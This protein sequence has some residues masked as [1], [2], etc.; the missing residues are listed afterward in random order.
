LITLEAYRK[1][2][3]TKIYPKNYIGA[4]LQDLMNLKKIKPVANKH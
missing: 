3:H 2:G 1:E 4:V